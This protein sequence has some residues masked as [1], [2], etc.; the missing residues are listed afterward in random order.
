MKTQE[1]AGDAG[2]LNSRIFRVLGGLGGF[3]LHF[4]VSR[5]TFVLEEGIHY[6]AGFGVAGLEH[7]A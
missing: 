2:E 5:T 1:D 4:V 7:Y 6:W 3:H